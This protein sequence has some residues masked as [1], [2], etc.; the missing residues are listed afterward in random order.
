[1]HNYIDLHRHAAVR[2]AMLDHPAVALRLVVAHAITGSGLWQVRPEPQ[3]AA[4]ETVTASL[5]GCKAEAAFGK[6]RREVLA[7]LGSPDEDSLVAGGNGDAVAIAGVFARLLALCDDDVMRVLTLVVAETL[8][9]GSAV[10]EALG[11]HLNVDMGIW[12]QPDDAFFDLLRD[13]EIANSMLADVGGKLVADGNV[14]EKVKTQKNIIR[15]FL[16]GEN[17]RPW[18][19]T[20][21]PRWM[22]FPAESY[23][24][25]SGSAPRSVD[26]SAAAVRARIVDQG[27]SGGSLDYRRSG[28][29]RRY[30]PRRLPIGRLVEPVPRAR[31]SD[32]SSPHFGSP[33]PRRV[34]C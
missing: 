30:G 3:R 19:E 18:V 24:S 11:N 27:P 13:K 28:R 33:A 8:A 17:G 34:A 10:V 25:R 1:M 32:A 12:W 20:W 23:T 31:N 7:L 26:T 2:A 15:D 16:A 14:A 21:L 22:K 29:A 5:A 6:K 9:A 4:N